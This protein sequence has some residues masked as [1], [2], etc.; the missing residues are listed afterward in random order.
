MKARITLLTLGVDDLE[1]A[2]RFYRAGLGFS[3]EGIVGTEYESRLGPL[4][5][6]EISPCT[7]MG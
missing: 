6:Q 2:L 3:T 7:P 4:F 1:R 5:L